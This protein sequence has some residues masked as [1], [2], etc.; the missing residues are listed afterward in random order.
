MI[1]LP[2]LAALLLVVGGTAEWSLAPGIAPEPFTS[3]RLAVDVARLA[4]GNLTLEEWV[5]VLA[6]GHGYNVTMDGIVT[7]DDGER[8]DI[9]ALYIVV[10]GPIEISLEHAP[11]KNDESP[12]QSSASCSRSRG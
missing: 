9:S 6:L 1:R 2:L 7:L 8:I 3:D 10:S 5:V 4:G 12:P 11:H